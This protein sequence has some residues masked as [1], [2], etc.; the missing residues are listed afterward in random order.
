[1]PLTPA[2]TLTATLQSIEGA[3]DAGSALLITL[4]GFGQELPH[5][6]GTSMLAKIKQFVLATSGTISIPIW[7]ND[8]ISPAGTY[9]SVAVLDDAKNVVQ[10]GI[11]QFTGS[12]TID[13]SNAPQLYLQPLPPPPVVP[14]DAIY[15]IVASSSTPVFSP[16]TAQVT[17]YDFTLTSNVTGSTASG[18]QEGQIVVFILR[19]AAPGGYTFAWPGTIKN[20]PAVNTVAGSVSTFAFVV[21]QNSNFYPLS[22]GVW[23]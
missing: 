15:V 10:S 9:Y 8:V 22:G 17:T 3:A 2:L 18:F 23:S 4:C 1:M 12:G 19:V 11:Y 21:D 7:G 5:I 13:L 16:T 14:T 20:P 6:A